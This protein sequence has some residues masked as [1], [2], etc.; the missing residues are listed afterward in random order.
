MLAKSIRA[1]CDNCEALSANTFTSAVETKRQLRTEGWRFRN[2]IHTC[3]TCSAT[4][5]N[6]RTMEAHTPAEVEQEEEI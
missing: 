2:G 4:R 1:V 5:T 6:T 3:P